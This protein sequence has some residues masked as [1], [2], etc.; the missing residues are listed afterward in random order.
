MSSRG[1]CYTLT[2][3][4]LGDEGIHFPLVLSNS[5]I[6]RCE[7]HLSHAVLSHLGIKK[8]RCKASGTT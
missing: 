8:N 2:Y 1:H 4:H 5:G 3:S 6:V 7:P